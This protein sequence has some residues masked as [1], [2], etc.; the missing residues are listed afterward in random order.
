MAA[1]AFAKLVRRV[2]ERDGAAAAAAAAQVPDAPAP[3]AAAPAPAAQAPAAHAPAAPASTAQASAGAASPAPASDTE[4]HERW[5]GRL[6]EDGSDP[7]DVGD[8]ADTQPDDELDEVD[9][10]TGMGHGEDAA[11]SPAPI[12]TPLSHAQASAAIASALERRFHMHKPQMPAPICTPLS[13]AQASET[14][15]LAGEVPTWISDVLRELFGPN[16]AASASMV[17]SCLVQADHTPAAAATSIMKSVRSQRVRSRLAKFHKKRAAKA[18]LKRIAKAN[19][20]EVEED[21]L[22]ILAVREAKHQIQCETVKV[23]AETVMWRSLGSA[24]AERRAAADAEH[25]AAEDALAEG[26]NELAKRGSDSE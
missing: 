8:L 23:Q 25:R 14:S 9:V 16:S 5:S 19:A 21:R 22:R 13:H 1:E 4:S 10:G 2:A 17:T 20:A 24:C 11:P 12:C 18:E 6:D 3:A 26:Q 7:G 15:P